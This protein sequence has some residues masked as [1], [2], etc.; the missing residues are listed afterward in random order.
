MLLLLLTAVI[1]PTAC[2]LWFMTQ[3]MRNE[4]LAVRQ[5][6]QDAYRGQLTA[7]RDRIDDQWRE[8][9]AAL[10]ISDPNIPAAR[11]F[12]RLVTSNTVDSVIICDA[13]GSI[14]YPTLAQV[15][16]TQ[17][18][19][20]REWQQARVLEDEEG[21]LK[22]A[23]AAYA[24][25]AELAK[26]ASI[27]AGALLAQTRCLAKVGQTAAAIDILT[28]KLA[29]ERYRD[30]TDAQGR[31]IQL[32]ALLRGLQ[33][34][35]DTKQA[36][37]RRV[38]DLLAG[39]LM[40]YGDARI[41][42]SQRR[43]LMRQLESTVAG[44]RPF[45]TLT[46]E[47][48][49]VECLEAADPPSEPARLARTRLR[50][51]WAIRPSNRIAV[52][53][54]REQTVLSHIQSLIRS[55][56]FPRDVSVRILSPDADSPGKPAFISEPSGSHLPGWRLALYLE[57]ADPFA[58]AASRQVTAYLWTGVLVIVVLALMAAVVAGYLIRQVRLTRLKNDLIATVTHELKTPL[59]SMRAL[60][61]TLL[62][63]NVRDERQAREYIQLMSKE[64][65]RLSHL[66]DNFLT[67][68]R[69]ERN[70]RTF[71]FAEVDMGE[72]INAAA[73]IVH[74]RFN[75]PGCG[76]DIQVPEDLPRVRAD[77]DAM[78]TVFLNLLDNAWKYSGDEKH[79]DVRAY[80]EDG[81]V[82]LEVRDNG[83]GMSRRATK[84]IFD[85]F[86]QVDQTLSRKAGGCGLGLSIVKFI[87]DAHGGSISVSSQPG[88]GSTFTIRLPLA[89]SQAPG[90]G[91]GVS[92]REHD[93]SL[94]ETRD[95]KPETRSKY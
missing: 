14:R 56:P 64:N 86:Y 15:T 65:E 79:I 3:A 29:H 88:K 8:K 41:P 68:S 47:D 58:A 69:M 4:R 7:V 25:I 84:R 71:Q 43:F 49:A 35:G 83:I 74:D 52:G 42:A 54:F 27:A 20:T 21:D 91:D 39:R 63:G 37:Q 95:P 44:C 51:V 13:S 60:V 77:R 30:A 12:E 18:A 32:D 73:G 57:G 33:L 89:I 53:L 2:V 19:E 93:F 46:A 23:A 6:L 67:F 1:V 45:P 70:K 17:E 75:G 87:V 82:C 9:M 28:K 76:L 40:D 26:D 5:K 92:G 16:T 48:L 90:V 34:M 50:Q 78:V 36:D 80:A 38:V 72:A 94:P 10:S 85:R 11:L 59:A 31:L 81:M 62:A 61:D 22:A 24:K 55:V 66:I